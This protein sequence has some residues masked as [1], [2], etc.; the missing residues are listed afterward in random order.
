LESKSGTIFDRVR[1]DILSLELSPDSPLRLPAL[2]KRYNTGQTP[3]RECL[4]RLCGEELVLPERNKGFRVAP[5]T[6]H[7]LL[8]LERS[9]NAIEGEMFVDSVTHADDNWEAGVVGAF[10][11]LSKTYT[12]NLFACTDELQKWTR[13]HDVFHAALIQR[14]DTRW[15]R[16]FNTQLNDQIGRYRRFIEKGL[17][18]LSR[19]HPVAAKQATEIFATAMALEPHKTLCE[20]ALTHDPEAARATFDAHTR[21]SIAAFESLT[22]MMPADTQ[23]ATTLGAQREAAP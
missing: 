16:R 15:M 5:L 23:L 14:S 3:L 22:E 1:A 2:S 11:Q 7:D 4:N 21:L 18:D 17:R 20:A 9:R 12:S 8:D 13:R 6:R 19:T 10:H